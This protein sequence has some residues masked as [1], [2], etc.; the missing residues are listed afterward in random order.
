MLGLEPDIFSA[1]LLFITSFISLPAY[2][3]QLYKILK[4]KSAD[5]CSLTSW[6][7]W[8]FEYILWVIYGVVYT[9]DIFFVIIC[10]TE[11]LLCLYISILIARYGHINKKKV[12]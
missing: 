3:S 10:A 12:G 6:G 2:I 11:L 5:G 7:V 1:I 8:A 4:T 9:R